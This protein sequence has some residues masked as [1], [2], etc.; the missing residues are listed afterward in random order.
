MFAQLF[1]DVYKNNAPFFKVALNVINPGEMGGT[2][3]WAVIAFLL[4]WGN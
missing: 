1:F 2:N 3:T 4:T